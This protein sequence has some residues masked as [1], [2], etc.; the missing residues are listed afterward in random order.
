MTEKVL[1]I[2][3][4][5]SFLYTHFN[6]DMVKIKKGERGFFVE[7]IEKNTNENKYSCPFLG[8]AKGGSLTV[9][10]FIEMKQNEKE[11]E[12]QNEKRLLP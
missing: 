1:S 10:K 5:P 7:P 2:K 4:L 6:T 9:D 8:T 3:S 11:L 12:R